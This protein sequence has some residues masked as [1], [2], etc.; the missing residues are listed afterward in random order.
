MNLL[1][2]VLELA[3]YLTEK[4]KEVLIQKLNERIP[5]RPPEDK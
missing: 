3:K 1:N 4:E 2:K 5:K